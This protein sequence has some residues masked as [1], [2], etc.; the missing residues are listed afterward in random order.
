MIVLQSAALTAHILPRGATLAGFWFKGHPRSLVLGF[1]DTMA[2]ESA[3]FYAGALV[4]PVANRVSNGQIEI[5]GKSFQMPK[6]ERENCLHS[7]D[8]GLNE[9]IWDVTDQTQ[10]SVTLT[11][12]LPDCANGLPGTRKISATYTLSDDSTL[13]LTIT[14][15]SDC[16]TVMNVAHHPYW[17]LDD[18]DDVSGH[19]LQVNATDYLPV[20]AQMLPTGEISPV[21]GSAYDFRIAR[22]V[23][24]D[25][26][27]DANLCVSTQRSEI[28]KDVAVLTGRG[29]ISL[30]IAS[31]E[32][33]LQ[34]Y[35]G[36]GLPMDGP[37]ALP[38]QHIRPFAGIALEPQSW[39]DAPT[40]P[41]FPSILLARDH[42][43]RQETHYKVFEN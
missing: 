30:R 11:T 34:I 21:A 4:G 8:G 37:S 14:A 24:V 39:P 31:T 25:Q 35:N 2:F 28:P 20:D 6:N 12:D 26:T 18:S 19:H 17:T 10:C 33:G 22:P 40:H 15:F 38:G 41:H 36:G 13:S 23:P 9:L 16:D 43:Y 32:P 7:G 5:A 27:L 42:V 3:A 29:G 1:S